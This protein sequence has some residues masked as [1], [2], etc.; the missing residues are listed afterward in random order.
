MAAATTGTVTATISGNAADLD[1]LTASG[2]TAT[3]AYTI[4]VDDAVTAAQGALIAA[5][6]NAAAVDFSAA[7]VSDTVGNLSAGGS[8]SS[9]LTSIVNKD[10]DVSITISDAAATNMTA[11]DLSAIGGATSGTV[12]VTNAVNITG[13]VAEINAALV[14]AETKVVLAGNANVTATDVDGSS[15]LS[16]VNPGG[17]LTAQLATG[18]NISGN[19]NLGTV[20]NFSIDTDA[21]VT[22]TIAQHNKISAA[23]D[24][25]NVTLFD[26][27]TITGNANVESYN[28]AAGGNNFTTASVGQTVVGNTGVDELT[29]GLGNDTLNGADGDDIL[30]GG[31]GDDRLIGGAG[32]DV[33]TGG[34]GSDTFVFASGASGTT[35][36]TKD[37]ITDFETA[38]DVLQFEVTSGDALSFTGV[39]AGTDGAR[40]F[41]TEF[42]AAAESAFATGPTNVYFAAAIGGTTN[43]YLAVDMDGN[44]AFDA[45][46]D[47]FMQLTG[48]SSVDDLSAANITFIV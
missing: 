40:I 31:L 19:T 10:A 17:T 38:S 44:G 13:T 47:V 45:G 6:T 20:D 1:D 11:S 34:G 48:L 42:I 35:D 37:T 30:I 43:G 46:T 28:L 27:G 12:T 2:T 5:A 22:M 23:A 15:D 26:N 3:H 25:N 4:T 21:N 36:A 32:Q 9:D 29:G 14:T 24:T 16:G 7:G 39:N 41:G 18:V 33:L 8:V